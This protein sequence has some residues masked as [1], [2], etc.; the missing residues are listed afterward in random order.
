[1]NI[2]IMGPPGA[3][4]GTQSEYIV[5]NFNVVHVSTGDMFRAAIKNE[6]Q[7][8]QLAK[9]YIDKGELVPDS[10]TNGIVKERLLM[11]DCQQ[12][13]LL[14]GYP[15]TVEQAQELDSFCQ[16]QNMNIDIVL[17]IDVDL[18]ILMARLT[19]RRI[20]KGCGASYHLEFNPSSTE[21]ICD[22]CGSELYQRPDDNEES[23]TV[24]LS[25]YLEQTKPL[26]DYYN[27]KGLLKNVD[28]LDSIDNVRKSI[29]ALLGE[30]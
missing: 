2:I 30:V 4:K 25:T 16:E 3:G 27:A 7:Y 17:N 14:D 22:K 1:M 18:E 6:T 13:F 29:D 12:G 15:R 10:V 19:G 26:I 5:T 24:R 9:Q 21:G 11:D 23:A 28:G 20:C 8:G